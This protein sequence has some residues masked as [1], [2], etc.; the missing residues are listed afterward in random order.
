MPSLPSELPHS[1]SM[2]V[3]VVLCDVYCVCV[4]CVLVTQ[5]HVHMAI[6]AQGSRLQQALW[7]WCIFMTWTDPAT[8]SR[9]PTDGLGCALFDT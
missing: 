8:F 1:V 4:M 6:H 9:Q 5:R 2:C 7:G 3:R